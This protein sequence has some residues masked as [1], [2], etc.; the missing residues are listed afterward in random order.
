MYS[1][2]REVNSVR[3]AI[4]YLG[5]IQV[6]KWIIMMSMLNDLTAS[7]GT[8]NLVLTRAKACENYIERSLSVKSDQAFLVG[9]LSGVHLL[10]GIDNKL[11]FEQISLPT[12]IEEAIFEEEGVLGQA[13]SKILKIE[14]AIMQNTS[15]IADQEDIGLSAYCDAS[16]WTEDVLAEV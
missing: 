14:Y 10:F 6:R 13:L 2:G 4:V 3:E 9:L 15:E 11:F 8:V 12:V 1:L 7:R 16:T 5:L